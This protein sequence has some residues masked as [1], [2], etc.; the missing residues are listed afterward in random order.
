MFL[1][2]VL[3]VIVNNFEHGQYKSFAFKLVFVNVLDHYI[4]SL[5]ALSSTSTFWAIMQNGKC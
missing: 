5:F 2:V 1:S 3:T 4:S